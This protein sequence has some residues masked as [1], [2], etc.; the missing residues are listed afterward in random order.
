VVMGVR[1][2]VAE[3]SLGAGWQAVRRRSGRAIVAR[4]FFLACA[5]LKPVRKSVVSRIEKSLF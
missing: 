1:L 5:I 3:E 2:G 4:G